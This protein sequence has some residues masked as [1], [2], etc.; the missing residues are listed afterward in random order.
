MP[1]M[2]KSATPGAIIK[3]L[4]LKPLPLEGG[5][6]KETFRSK[7]MIPARE[8]PQIYRGGRAAGTA[9]YYLLTAGT[10]SAIH[11]LPGD[12]IYHFYFGDPVE[13]FLFPGQG[14]CRRIILGRHLASGQRPQALVP[15]GWWQGA[16]LISR[17]R[18]ALLGTTMA[19]GFD[20]RDFELGRRAELIRRFPKKRRLILQLTREP[21]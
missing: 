17:G 16:R 5:F 7:Q 15:G 19:P 21:D 9:I 1:P 11:R 13:L 20:F 14:R 8:L 6:F 10:F 2:I 12:E 18:F 4:G 3:L